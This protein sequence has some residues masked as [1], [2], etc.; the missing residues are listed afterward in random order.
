MPSPV[1]EQIR[2]NPSSPT[3][4]LRRM[5]LRLH[6]KLGVIAWSSLLFATLQS[7]CTFFAALDGLRTAIGIGAFAL[8]ESAGKWIDRFHVDWLRVPMIS[9]AVTGSL[10][11][12]LVLWQ[13]RRLRSKPAAQWRQQP[14]S[15]RKLRMEWAQIALA[16]LTLALVTIEERQHL[17]WTGHL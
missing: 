6:S 1:A 3:W 16:V 8:A 9:I 11:N 13:V 15:A 4:A 10:L 12:L 14:V 5:G 2:E 7:V 17:L